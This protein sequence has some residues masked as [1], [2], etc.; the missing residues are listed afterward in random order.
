[1]DETTVI[2]ICRNAIVTLIMVMGPSLVLMMVVGT[3][4]SV[5]QAVT[6]INEQTL[7][8]VPKLIAV[9]ASSL[10]LMPYMLSEMQEYFEREIVDRIAA[11]G[12]APVEYAPPPPI[13]SRTGGAGGAGTPGSAMPGF[14]A[15]GTAPQPFGAA[16]GS[17]GR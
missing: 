12:A 3:T 2:A 7:S 5:F 6:S 14:G 17:P 16:P 15:P 1:M 11:V 8:M 9:F 4:I 10:L 13:G